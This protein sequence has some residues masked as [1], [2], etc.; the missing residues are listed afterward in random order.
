MIVFRY[1]GALVLALVIYPVFG[2]VWLVGIACFGL[3]TLFSNL[4]SGFRDLW[5]TLADP[6]YIPNIGCGGA[7]RRNHEK[8]LASQAAAN[9]DWETAV[10]HW[11]V[12]GR[13]YDIHSMFELGKCFETGL[14]T[15]PSDGAAYEYYSMAALYGM[16][17]GR[18]ACARLQD[19]RFS[20]KE[21]KEFAKTMWEE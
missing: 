2:L 10:R 14:G 9:G 8:S 3:S 6:A 13:L 16:P 12:A 18:E 5:L 11:K 4:W 15:A 19:H 21:R 7:I 20:S 1:L 17:E